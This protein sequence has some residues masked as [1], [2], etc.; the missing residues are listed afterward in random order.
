MPDVFISHAEEDKPVA[1]LVCEKLEG[2]GLGC[3]IAPRDIRPGKSWAAAI[4]DAIESCR[5]VVL[6]LSV[7]SVQSRQIAREVEL[8]DKARVPVVTLR[9]DAV[10]LSGDLEYFLSNTQWLDAGSDGVEAQLDPLIQCLRDSLRK[11]TGVIA[12]QPGPRAAQPRQSRARAGAG[13]VVSELRRVVATWFAV[14]TGGPRSVAAFEFRDLGT[15]TFALRFAL[16]MQVIAALVSFPFAGLAQRHPAAYVA[17][18]V[19]SETMEILAAAAI[20]HWT[21]RRLGGTGSLQAST[22][23]LC[24][25]GALWPVLAVSLVPLKTNIAPL[26]QL[27]Q[28]ATRPE[29][30]AEALAGRLSAGVVIALCLS[31]LLS[32]AAIAAIVAGVFRSFRAAHNVSVPRAFLAFL[33][34]LVIYAGFLTFVA[35]PFARALYL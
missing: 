7:N 34:A 4:V 2:A 24:L 9:I 8:A 29:D 14:V 11:G 31:F 20:L 18:Y 17:L 35:F 1:A 5:A 25:Y 10:E 22:A 33:I 13:A 15:L 26:L 32:T 28:M 6:L 19:L 30:L 16:Y 23:V 21:F 3:W 27:Q 12:A